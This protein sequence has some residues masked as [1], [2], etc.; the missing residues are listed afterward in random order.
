MQAAAIRNARRYYASAIAGRWENW[1]QQNEQ[2]MKGLEE[3]PVNVVS[4]KQR[5]V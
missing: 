1:L 3:K 2:R 5:V 4:L